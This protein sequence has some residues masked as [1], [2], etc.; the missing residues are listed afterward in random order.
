MLLYLH[1]AEIRFEGN[2]SA[3]SLVKHNKNSR[4]T[5]FFIDRSFG[6]ITTPAQATAMQ[7]VL[8]VALFILA[9]YMFSKSGDTKVPTKTPQEFINATLPPGSRN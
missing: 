6:L 7:L 3:S 9:G 8:A 1:M 4:M 5:Q 2:R